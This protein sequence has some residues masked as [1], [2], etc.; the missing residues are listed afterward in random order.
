MWT[1]GKLTFHLY[2]LLIGLGILAGAGIS[3][4]MA[5]KVK[6]KADDIWDS[7]LWVVGGGVVGA[8]IYHVIDLWEYYWY[9]PAEILAVW[10][11]GL[12]IFGGIIGGALGLWWY[13]KNKQKFI[14]ILD[15]AALGLPVGQAIGRW[16]NYF[17]QELYG[18]P[19]KL[20]WG[21]FIKVENR[22]LSVIE[23]EKFHPL[24]FY[25]SLWSL[26]VLGILMW[27]VKKKKVKLGTGEL[28]I[29]YLGLYGWG[30]FWLEWLRIESWRIYGVNVGQA[31]SLGL[32][33]LAVYRFKKRS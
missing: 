21:M 8:R 32:V 6:L 7:L 19:T 2:G 1:L 16:G 5:G 10:N 23:Y 13:T 15:L 12:G 27:L 3:A 26:V 25:E 11:G 18:K 33:G 9:Y 28:F 4:R 30:R 31:I 14:K 29:Y 22:L 24:F 17:N 20:A